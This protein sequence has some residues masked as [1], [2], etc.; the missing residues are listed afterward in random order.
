MNRYE[1]IKQSYRIF[2]EQA[3]SI[4]EKIIRDHQEEEKSKEDS[5][6]MD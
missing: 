6:E 3:Q 1:R 2:P 5:H 4:R